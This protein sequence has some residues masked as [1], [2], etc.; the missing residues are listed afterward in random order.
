MAIG[1]VC[2]LVALAFPAILGARQDRAES[3]IPTR[4]NAKHGRGWFFTSEIRLGSQPFN[5]TF[6]AANDESPLPPGLERLPA[7]GQAITAP[8]VEEFLRERPYFRAS[9]PYEVVGEVGEQGLVA[10]DELFAYVGVSRSDLPDAASP[11]GGFGSDL[12]PEVDIA[13]GDLKIIQLSLLGLVGVPLAVYFAVCAR[14]SAATRNRRLAALRL[15]G[16]TAKETQRVNAVESIAAATIGSLV[17]LGLFDAGQ[18]VFASSRLGGIV[19]FRHDSDP[20]IGLL[21]FCAFGIP[22]LAALLSVAGS[23]G[24]VNNALAV[25][26]QAPLRPPGWWRLLPLLAGL[27]ILVGLVIQGLIRDSSAGLGDSGGMLLMSG[28]FLT[29][30]G[31]ALGFVVVDLSVARWLASRAKRLS[32]VLGLRRLEFEPS[33]PARVVSGLVV[34]VFGMGF[35]NGLQRDVQASNS[36]LE[37]VE[38]YGVAAIEMAPASREAL[39]RVDGIEAVLVNVQSRVSSPP[40]GTG[41]ALPPSALPLNATWA[42]C[43]DVA[44]FLDLELENCAEHAAYRVIPLDG[45][46]VQPLRQP[47][48]R[49]RFPL[50]MNRTDR[51]PDFSVVVPEETLGLA[52]QDIDK[53]ARIELLLPPEQLP[54]EKIPETASIEF[55]SLPGG[56]YVDQVTAGIARIAPTATISFLDENPDARRQ[57]AVVQQLLKLALILGVIVGAAAFLVTAL[58]QAVERRENLVALSIVGVP[59][60]TLRA[61]QAIQ[62]GVPLVL[63]TLVAV[64]AGRLAEQATVLTGG[65]VRSWPWSG[66]LV[67]LGV[68]LVSTL[69]ALL[70]MSLSVSGRI[71][72]SMIRRE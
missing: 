50:E 48:D 43:Q 20:S 70:I 30:I 68:G 23:R 4:T 15:L 16:M 3:R 34:V 40:P 21:F 71:D 17:G 11:L 19:W 9:F 35:A 28:L 54:R 69:I 45:P 12:N 46:P 1:V 63:G 61:A 44:F 42:T 72:V 49:I 8:R 65:Y 27:G 51:G 26:R 39:Y 41:D 60:R 57:S 38:R 58:D 36:S 31:L 25:R 37:K 29:A 24:A 66:T 67:G 5:V 7:P 33:G 55:A 14:L 32:V 22:F 64:I 53:L 62:V 2:L 52:T 56:R 18:S 10:P 13:A 59:V 47:G 6:I